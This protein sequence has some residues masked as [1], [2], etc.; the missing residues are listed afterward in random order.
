MSHRDIFWG[1]VKL[2]DM[3][4]LWYDCYCFPLPGPIHCTFPYADPCKIYQLT[5]NQQIY[6]E[7]LLCVKHS[8]AGIT[9]VNRT[10]K[11]LC[12]GGANILVKREER[13]AN[14]TCR[15]SD[16]H[17]CHGEGDSRSGVALLEPWR[18]LLLG[19]RS[20]F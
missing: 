4:R 3:E 18:A 2:C 14:N 20:K 1:D 5:V 12:S 13:Q 11:N 7:H 15:R 16:G 8:G 19:V 17:K 10:N 9:A 6:M